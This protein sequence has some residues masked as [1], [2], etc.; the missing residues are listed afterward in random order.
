MHSCSALVT[1]VQEIANA[2]ISVDTQ[3]ATIV[4][5]GS[6]LSEKS[7]RST[8]P[9]LSNFRF[10]R[11][12]G[13]RR[14]FRHPGAPIFFTN[15]IAKLD[16]LEIASLSTEPAPECSFVCSVFEIEGRESIEAFVTREAEYDFVKVQLSSLNGSPMLDEGFM[17]TASTDSK[18]L[19]KYGQEVFN[20][21]FTKWGL[22]TVWG[23]GPDSGILPCP[24]Y[25][26]HCVLAVK[27]QSQEILDNFLDETYLADRITTI[28]QYL[29]QNPHI[30]ECIPPESLK[31]RY[32]G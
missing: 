22:P 3:S 30:M 2:M 23:W 1:G 24:V 9:E 32:N 27:K 28:R 7:A 19:E 10:A 14:V 26:R 18:V 15:G 13:Y 4:G 25:L 12:H 16:T 29:D 5:F 6:L 21:M 31:F 11:A 8:F 20:E 17:C